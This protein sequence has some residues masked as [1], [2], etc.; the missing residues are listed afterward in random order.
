MK[1]IFVYFLVFTF[2][3]FLT[4]VVFAQNITLNIL[5]EDV[6]ETQII[7]ALLP[8]FEAKTGI[9]IEFESILYS[10]MHPKLIPQLMSPNCQYDVLE[11]DNY[12][13]GE[14]PAAGWLEP[15]DNYVKKSKF[16][17]SKYISSTIEMTGYYDGTLY[18]IPMYNYAMALIYR[19]DLMNDTTLR[20]KY[21]E[22]K[23]KDLSFP[24]NLGEY[25]E[26]C[27]FMKK[28][29]GI[30]GTAMQAQRGDP[31]VMEWTNYLYALGGK[32]YDENWKA[33]INDSTA[34]EATKL[35]VDC[36]KNAA[37]L[38][39]ASFNLDDAFRTMSQGK[40]FSFITYWWM[41]A[42]LEDSSKS[43][44]AGKVAVAPL[45][46][47]SGLNGGWGWAIP[48][49]ISEERKEAAWKFIEWVESFKI[50]KKRALMGGAVTRYDVFKDPDVLE[51]YPA[52]EMV[53]QVIEKSKPVPEFQFS[54][55]MIEVLGREL[56]LAVT[57]EKDIKEALDDAAKE[58]NVL[59]VKADLQR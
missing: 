34:V 7:Q 47:G 54:A 38:G 41:L 24:K 6:P 31:I 51:K 22:I 52:Y 44:V 57:G 3:F 17:L 21:K 50:T 5:M 13:A 29:E 42:S 59:A 10:D 26:L 36:L 40:S 33:T 32:F 19:T 20:A 23:K 43:V 30:D 27:K 2:L 1:R 8:E 37:P 16:D 12:W 35:Y 49:N 48:K 28:Y 25:V 11:V 55:Q 53:M 46:G 18:M 15:L 14:F 4:G 39:A 45:P 58:F 9:N 56:S